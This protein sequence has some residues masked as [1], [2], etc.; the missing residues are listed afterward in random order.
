[1]TNKKYEN[2]FNF[3]LFIFFRFAKKSIL[4]AILSALYTLIDYKYELTLN[5]TVL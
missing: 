1:M 3:Q 5:L 4:L 2:F